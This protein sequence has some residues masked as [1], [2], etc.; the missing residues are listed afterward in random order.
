LWDVETGK[1]IVKWKGHSAAVEVVCWSPD[2]G[3][4]VSGSNDGTARVWDVKSSEPIQ[5][6]NPI[7]TGQKFVNVVSYSPKARKIATSGFIDGIKIWDGKTGQLL[8]KINHEQSWSLTW[9]SDDKKLISGTTIGSII[10]FDT[11]TWQQIAVL[12]GHSHKYV[13]A[14]TISPDN[15]L[16]AS[17]SWDNTARL[18]NLDTSLQVGPPL[19][20]TDAVEGV[21]FS[22][23]GK[24][25]STACADK[26]LGIRG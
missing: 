5:G 8:F 11:A 3:R 24:L 21:A 7:K 18:W 20:H 4:V 26:N 13:S 12:E 25:L 10:I 15:R 23:D 22:P 14:I 6:M 9:T 19:E 2:S 1:V 17:A 16:L